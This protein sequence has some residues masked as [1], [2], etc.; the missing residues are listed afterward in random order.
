METYSTED[1]KDSLRLITHVQVE[2]AH[3][4]DANALLP[5]IYAS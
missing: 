4:S 1:K 2:Q 3:Q 5:A